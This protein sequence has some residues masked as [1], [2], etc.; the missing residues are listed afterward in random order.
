MKSKSFFA[1]HSDWWWGYFFV[2]PTIIGLLILNFYP[3]FKTI[4]MS[5]SESGAFNTFEFN[6]IQNYITLLSDSQTWISLRNTLIFSFTSVPIGIFIAI[7]L[8]AMMSQKLKGIGV[9]RVLYFAPMLAAPAAV[10]MIW[11]L[12]FNTDYG[13]LNSIFGT[14][15]SW[16]SNPKWA[17]FSVVVI[18]IWSGLG[19]QIII[20]IAAITGVSKELYEAAS[21]DG[22]GPVRQ[23]FAV[24]IPQISPSIFFLSITGFI[25][26]I[27]QFDIIYMI[28]GTSGSPAMDSVRT[29]MHTYYVQAFVAQNKA[30]ASAIVMVVFVVVLIFT[31]VQFIGEKKFVN[32]D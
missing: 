8:A 17:M 6:G 9:Y 16:L 20:L 31:G 14:H 4:L 11:S 30:Y 27:K 22:A 3:I 29:L 10:S 26:A 1:K 24:T 12:I 18:A 15:I 13:I 32:Y 28:Y 2:A 25:G 5:F 23:L 21:L 19:Q 7:I